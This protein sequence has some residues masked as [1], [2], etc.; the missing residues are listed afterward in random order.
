MNG[1]TGK[2]EDVHKNVEAES[3]LIPEKSTLQ[4][5]M[6]GKNVMGLKQQMKAATLKNVHVCIIF[7]V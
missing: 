4:Q 3:K 6:E 2:L 5:L 1:Q 7:L